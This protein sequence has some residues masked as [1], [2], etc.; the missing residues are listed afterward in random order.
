MRYDFDRP[1][2]RRGTD[3]IKWD[4]AQMFFP[5]ASA[6]ALPLWVA[7]M[8]LPTAQ[9]IVDA[10]VARARHPVY[11]YTIHQTED[12]TDSVLDW[13]HRRF[14]WDIDPETLFHAPGVVTALSMFIQILTEPGDGVIIQQPVYYPFAQIIARNKRVLL[15][16]A[17]VLDGDRYEMDFDDLEAKARLPNA[18]LLIL[19][20][21]HNPVGRVWT[22][23]ELV[24]LT[25]ICAKH[26]V[27]V[28]SD[29]IH[30][31]LLRRGVRHIPLA[32]A[33]PEHRDRIIV[34]TAPSKTFNL[35]GLKMS[36]I[37]IHSQDIRN[38]FR[39]FCDK[40]FLEGGTIF[41]GITTRVAYQHGE[42]WLEQLVDYLDA[43]VEFLKSYLSR[44]LPQAPMIHPEGT[45]LAWIDFSAYGLTHRELKKLF[46]KEAGVV[47]DDGRMFGAEG[48]NFM[49]INFACPKH[50]LQECL[51]RITRA[52][53]KAS[54][55][56][57]R[58]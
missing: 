43:N 55:P 23:Q 35:P 44:H 18:K 39:T 28:I 19:C 50:T 6:N 9:P 53:R 32:K 46:L 38:R 24:R 31:D 49:R 5:D 3:S 48:D 51:D 34:A 54:S 1:V 56:G 58:S 12:Y 7:D 27:V 17:L 10:L 20:S 57:G 47:L 41:G 4:F 52:M 37:F 29:E 14:G 13:F 36:N 42:E 8:D 16:N 11:G 26:D 33:C 15:N 2:E 25:T 40:L 21:P 45:Y 22:E 30:C